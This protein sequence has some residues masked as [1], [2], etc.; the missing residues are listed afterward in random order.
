PNM[1]VMAPS[2]ERELANMVHSMAHYD[3][4]PIS[5]RYP[6]GNG[7]GVSLEGEKEILPIG[8]GRLIRRGKKVAILS[9]GTRLEESLKA[10]DRLDAQGLS[11]S[12]ADMRFAKPLDEALTRQLL[13]SH[14]VIITIE[15]GA[16]GGFATQV[17]T[18]A[19][20]EG[21]MDDGLK[22]RTLRLPDRF[23]P[24]DKQER[25]YAEA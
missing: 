14:Q 9:L 19:S 22:I 6:R 4:G 2:D 20:D 11:T 16:L 8:K 3:Q 15:E 1:V 5:V 21:L 7:V 10:A 17:L 24:Q 25:Q 23:Q 13:K 18:M 12:V